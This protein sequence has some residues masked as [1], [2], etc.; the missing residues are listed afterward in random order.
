MTR[1]GLF[2]AMA[3]LALCPS[4]RALDAEKAFETSG[5]QGGLVVHLGCGDG[6]ATAALGA[7]DS[8]LVHGLDRDPRAVAA[9][10]KHIASLGQYGRVSVDVFDGKALPYTDNLVNLLVADQ[11]GGVP[12]A[13]VTRV[14]A[15]RGVAVIGGRKTVKPWPR[16]IDEWTHFLYDASG[17]AVAKDRRVASP[18][19]IQWMAGPK[20]CRH[21]DALASMSA[22][23]S[24]RGRLF[25]IFDEGPTALMH[26]PPK[27][28]LIARDAFNGV[29]LWKREIPTWVTH[30]FYFRTGPVQMPR[31]LVSVGDRV[32]VTLGFDAP[33]SALDAATGRTLHTF[34]GS[35]KTEE[36]I[37]HQGTL[38][39]VVGDP[40]IMN[41]EAPKVYGYWELSVK[42]EPT[43]E[44][45]IVACEADT[46]KMLWR[47]TGK[48][49]AH[50]VPLSLIAY[51]DKVL[52]LD[53]ERLH[54]VR[55]RD[56]GEV[57]T[58]P[59]PT[60]GLFLRNYAPT[61]VAYDDVVMCLTWDRLHAFALADGKK[62]WQ[63]K[64]A[65][66]FASP[67]DL[68]AID[69]LA[70]V[71]PHTAAIWREN[72]VDK[73]GRITSGIN[74][75]REDFLG[76]GGT[77]IWGIDLHTGEVK[78][79]FDR[80]KVLPGGHH[81]R[82]YRN[83]ATE[84]FLI[85]GR[86]GLEYIDLASDNHVN[87]WWVRGVCQY[88]VMPAN[89]L[90]YVPTDPCQCFNLIK[91]NGFNALA[92]TNSLDAVEGPV[93][94][95]LTKGPAYG[96]VGKKQG[97]GSR[98]EP[99]PAG[100]A[101]QAPIRPPRPDEW[102]TY[103]ADV[104]RSGS[105]ASPVPV[106][107][108]P[109]WRAPIGPS[110]TASTV[111][112]DRLLVCAKDTHTV[113]CLNASDGTP[114]WQFAAGGRVDSPPTIHGDLCVFG[115]ADGAVYCLRMSDGAL[116]WRHRPVLVDR[117]VVA[118]S[119]LESVWPVSGSVLVQD[120]VAY[121]AAGRSS[122]LDGGIRLYG[123]DVYTGETLH[124]TTVTGRPVTPG[125]PRAK[126]PSIGALPDLLVSDGTLLNMRH[127][128]FDRELKLQAAAQIKTICASTGL[129]EDEWT[130]R[131]NWC[132]GRRGR[133]NSQAHPAG[134]GTERTGVNS[135]LSKLIVFDGAAA[136]G[137]KTPY[138][139]QK[140]DRSLWP[141][142]HDGHLHQKYARYEARY[143]PV[144]SQLTATRNGAAPGLSRDERRGKKRGGPAPAAVWSFRESVQPRAMVLAGDRLF[145][146]GWHDAMA[147][148][149]KTGR[150]LHPRNPDP[151]AAFLWVL[152]TKD[153]KR[154]AEYELDCEPAFDAM[155]AAYG[156]LFL[157]T[158][159]GSIRCMGAAD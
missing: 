33:V 66:G 13:E 110:P 107:L 128:Q 80:R 68:F 111:A 57:W 91:L 59:F 113:H 54:C 39:A 63:L 62:L 65:I 67:G 94:P 43:V 23:T 134:V 44:K 11:L 84:R 69:G 159:D 83:K 157:S 148:E 8:T 41:D 104:T 95:P 136:Y 70:W 108:K 1:P 88:G 61:V 46:G 96:S 40:N 141:A 26:R 30:L 144:G 152:S 55:L 78:K 3:V 100:M 4:A 127:L 19:R 52:F 75:P 34:Q 21:H 81:A 58:A 126:E 147:V 71:N 93:G 38:L 37:H 50:L 56:G 153:G 51:G 145:L 20:R 146:A 72:K 42:R 76:N 85:C 92:A 28:R 97:E 125:K 109:L 90:I 139:W 119:R 53:N 149:E 60:E 89:G 103:R 10:Q 73:N 35:Q 79:A 124:E 156:R 102:P 112:G 117:R 132:L 18:R 137:V 6:K 135:P 114:I 154:L 12:M 45:A 122:Y 121:F 82:C 143:F 48:N 2:L 7:S 138:S 49:L 101:W 123:L 77:E 105:T 29:L 14:L 22:M 16:D 25:Y 74:I 129:L 106:K 158:K 87:N 9:A 64:G 99:A 17:N 118:N 47:K 151:R 27:W 36:I 150:A 32:F 142:G 130:H 116:A 131:Q 15:P 140:H 31:R 98:V 120:G 86:R 24:S 115:C 155:S 133:I 5:V